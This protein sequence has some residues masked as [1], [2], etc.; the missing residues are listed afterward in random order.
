[1]VDAVG[2]SSDIGTWLAILLALI[3]LIG[4]VTPLLLLRESRSERSLAINALDSRDTGFVTPG[5]PFRKGTRLFRK[6]RAP[7]LSAPPTAAFSLRACVL[8]P[9]LDSKTGWINLAALVTAYAPEVARGDELEIINKKAW[10]PCHRFW[11][12]ALGLR[13]RYGHRQDR[14][15]EKVETN[16]SGLIIDDDKAGRGEGRDSYGSMPST[17]KLYGITGSI[18]WKRSLNPNEVAMDEV[19]FTPHALE[20]RQKLLPDT[21]RTS[22]LFWLSLGCL[23]GDNARVYELHRYV[24]QFHTVLPR[25]EGSS[26]NSLRSVVS[27]RQ[28]TPVPSTPSEVGSIQVIALSPPPKPHAFYHFVRRGPLAQQGIYGPWMDSMGAEMSHLWSIQKIPEPEHAD[29]IVEQSEREEGSWYQLSEGEREDACYIWKWDVHY[30]ALALIKLDLSPKGFLFNQK[31]DIY[32]FLPKRPTEIASSLLDWAVANAASLGIGQDSDK[33]E[34]MRKHWSVLAGGHLDEGQSFSRGRAKL[35]YDVDSILSQR[36]YETPIFVR[37]VIGVLALTSEKFQTSIEETSRAHYD[38]HRWQIEIDKANDTARTS[39]NDIVWVTH[40]ISYSDVFP[41]SSQQTTP[42]HT[43]S[44][45]AEIMLAAL[46][47]CLRSVTFEN[48]IDSLPLIDLV[49]DMGEI[50]HVSSDGHAPVLIDVEGARERRAQQRQEEN[51]EQVTSHLEQIN[52]GIGALSSMIGEQRER[53]EGSFGWDPLQTDASLFPARAENHSDQISSEASPSPKERRRFMN[54]LKRKS[55]MTSPNPPIGRI[56]GQLEA[57]AAANLP[58]HPPTEAEADA[59]NRSLWSRCL[60][61]DISL[62]TLDM[63]NIEYELEGKV[64]FA[65]SPI[66]RRAHPSSLALLAY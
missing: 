14:G 32:N 35:C 19:F 18:R 9:G 57:A 3:A 63:F 44:N 36:Q 49:K 46:K 2:L 37:N 5:L 23:P 40:S 62:E 25:D 30:L 61:S 24:E 26:G 29:T 6:I 12:L 45:H 51:T 66:P 39:R 11:I 15:Y 31:N 48:T 1:M 53:D 59:E 54:Q 60:R 56:K 4:I 34:D 58:K 22:T 41:D 47:A 42:S 27:Y 55:S 43:Y 16:V 7:V 65:I 28:H 17:G 64:R 52:R 33:F 50:V 38:A 13:G 10:M 20:V 8:A 21:L